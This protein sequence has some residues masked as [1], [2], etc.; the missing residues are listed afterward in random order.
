MAPR[1]VYANL[2]DGLQPFSLFDQSLA[3][4]GNLGIIPCTAVGTNAI[5]LTA[6]TSVFA[7]TLLIPPQPLQ[8]FSFVAPANST[9]PITIKV[10]G[11]AFLNLYRMDGI[12]QASTGDIV[13]NVLYHIGYN[14]ALN[15]SV[16]G[17][18][19]LA[20]VSNEINPMISGATISNSTIT[21]STYN[22]NIWTAG[23]GT[24]TIAT[25]KTLKADNSLEFAG[26]DGTVQ[27]FPSTS[28]TVLTSV[29]SA[30]GDLTGTYPSPTIAANAVT[31]AKFRQGVAMSVVG[32]TG[33]ATAN[34]ADIAGTANQALVVNSAGTALT[35]GAVNL[36]SASAVT[37]NLS[38]N[39][40][41]SGTGATSSTFWRGDGTWSATPGSAMVLLNTLTP[42][43][44]ATASDTTSLT[45]TFAS[46]EI[47]LENLIPATAATTLNLQV[48]SGG[49]FQ[50]TSYI[51]E[52]QANT[53]GAASFAQ[54]TTFI[55]LGNSQNNTGPG[56]SGTVK[57][58]APSG[59]ASAKQWTALCGG[60]SST[61]AAVSVITS[62]YWNN[63]A[64]V[65]G[66]QLLFS[67]GNITSGTI[68]IY[69][70]T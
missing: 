51:T 54:P 27:T 23:T 44:V 10:D 65:D 21:T 28:G 63:T 46:Y 49:S 13:A 24:L 70:I 37:G 6:I 66:F 64:A 7:P 3:D 62:G 18:Q 9:A 55:Q 25:G 26:T 4:M 34:V 35:F 60:Q 16:G 50:A 33:N 47:I 1:T 31:N 48:H 58:F 17:F 39:N 56:I 2:Q 61:P 43:G 52:T 59:T 29:S 53:A 41:N 38:V 45:A 12:T 8:V 11:N 22:G 67:A 69:G 68:K 42:S 32:V 40:L 30:G 15:S 36:A 57:V 20:P 5:A 19:I 14:A